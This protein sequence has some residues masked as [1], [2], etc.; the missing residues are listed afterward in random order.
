[1]RGRRQRSKDQQVSCYN[2]NHLQ[3]PSVSSS[4]ASCQSCSS[5]RMKESTMFLLIFGI[6]TNR[7]FF[8]LQT[9]ALQDFAISNRLITPDFVPPLT[10]ISFSLMWRSHLCEFHLGNQI[11]PSSINS[12]CGGA[13]ITWFSVLCWLVFPTFLP[14]YGYRSDP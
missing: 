12:I 4:S 11:K 6:V 10:R 9:S 8:R 2:F 5:A 14:C 7:I 13:L 3:N 1:M